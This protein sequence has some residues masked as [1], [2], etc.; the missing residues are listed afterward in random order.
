MH[1]TP[2][3]DAMTQLQVVPVVPVCL[4]CLAL[5]LMSGNDANLEGAATLL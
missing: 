2:A 4:W 3:G 1:V 5:S